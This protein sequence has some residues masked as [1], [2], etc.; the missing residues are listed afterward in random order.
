M[1]KKVPSELPKDFFCDA[2][3]NNIVKCS[4]QCYYCFKIELK[5]NA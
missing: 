1:K 2:V 4:Y 5:Q 3:E